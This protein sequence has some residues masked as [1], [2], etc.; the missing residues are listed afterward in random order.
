MA[1]QGLLRPVKAPFETGDSF[2]LVTGPGYSRPTLTC[3]VQS[4]SLPADY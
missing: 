3:T 1:E 4:H 2:L